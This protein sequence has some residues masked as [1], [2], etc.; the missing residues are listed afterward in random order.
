M[1]R[2]ARFIIAILIGIALGL[3]YGWLI[4]PVEYVDTPPATL[5]I[6][7]KTDYILMVAEV[8][9][10][11]Q[12][13]D[14]AVRRLAL[15]GETPPDEIVLQAR[16]FAEKAGYN[17]NDLALL[18]ALLEAIRAYESPLEIPAS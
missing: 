10:A 16:S 4:N 3:L 11:N 5:R 1:S 12:D 9:H 2:W 6:D 13:I 17:E 18:Q 14:Q 7:Y 8:Y 15:L